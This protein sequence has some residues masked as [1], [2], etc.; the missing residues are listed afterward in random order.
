MDRITQERCLPDP[1]AQLGT[2]C[3]IPEQQIQVEAMYIPRTTLLSV[4]Y[5]EKIEQI[6]GVRAVTI[7]CKRHLVMCNQSECLARS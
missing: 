6:S 1:G 3:A 4:A 7:L 2:D 5:E